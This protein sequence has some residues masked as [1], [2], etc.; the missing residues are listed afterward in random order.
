V[1][2]PTWVEAHSFAVSGRMVPTSSGRPT[3]TC[4]APGCSAL[5]NTGLASVSYFQDLFTK[6][7]ARL[8]RG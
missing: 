6:S 8:S 1:I 2:K 7:R 3:Q 4:S 5:A